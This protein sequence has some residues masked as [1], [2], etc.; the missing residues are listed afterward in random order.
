M[1][2]TT[3]LPVL[4]ATFLA[5]FLFL[6]AAGRSTKATWIIPAALSA[7]FMAFSVFT[8]QQEG[9]WG[10][11][12]NHSQDLWGNQVWID[13]LFGIGIA[14]AFI[15]PEARRLKMLLPGWVGIILLTGC[16]GVLVMVARLLW[17]KEHRPA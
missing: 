17:L 8:I 4:A 3:A 12:E 5:A 2:V 11:W 10:F 14:W 9:L 6:T 16:I 15:L 1:Q 13:L 7:G